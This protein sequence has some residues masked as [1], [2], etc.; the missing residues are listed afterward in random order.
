[1][2]ELSPSAS[3]RNP[4]PTLTFRGGRCALRR[5]SG[6]GRQPC[7]VRRAPCAVRRRR[8][9]GRGRRRRGARPRPAPPINA[10]AVRLPAR[11]VARR[12]PRLVAR[13][14]HAH[15]A[16][17]VVWRVVGPP[18]GDAG[19][20]RGRGGAPPGGGER[21]CGAAPPG[22]GR[23]P[24][25]GGAAA[26]RGRPRGSYFV[27]P[28]VTPDAD[29]FPGVRAASGKDYSKLRVVIDML[30]NCNAHTKGLSRPHEI[31]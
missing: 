29:M 14:G 20:R 25:A 4:D 26:P 21:G 12:L 2:R 22:G 30:A 16:L 5:A 18:V 15:L 10:D 24:Q 28:L 31:I 23:A 19:R 17:F 11:D 3:N 1:M 8:R 13:G 9:E 6:A 7:A 27:T